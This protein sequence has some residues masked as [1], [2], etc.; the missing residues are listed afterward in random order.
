MLSFDVSLYHIDWKNL[1]LELLTPKDAGYT[2]N[3]SRAKSQGVELSV[4]SRPLS[5]LKIAAWVA[6][7]DAV[8]T[9]PFPSNSSSYGVAGDRLPYG[10]RFSGNFSIDQTFPVTA[11]VKGFVG[12]SVSYVG[13]REGQFTGS[14]LRQTFPAYAKTDVRAG[15]SYE[16]WTGNLFVTNLA[17][18]RGLL[19]GG[20]G[21]FNP[22]AFDYIQPRTIGLSVSKTF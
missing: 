8:L 5:S 16:S 13:D 11:T 7:N 3:A 6:L 10:S 17:D 4:D 2:S 21:T 1:Q 18:K 9:E 22:I 15:V 12:G 19:T 14:A 20:I